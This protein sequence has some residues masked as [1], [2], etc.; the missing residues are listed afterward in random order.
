MPSRPMPGSRASSKCWKAGRK[1]TRKSQPK[2]H[3][4]EAAKAGAAAARGYSGKFV[5][6]EAAEERV[7]RDARFHAR[8]IHAG[9]LV[10]AG[11]K[12]EMPV[13]IA[14]DV[15]AFGVFE[16][17]RI[18]VRGADAE[19]HESPGREHHTADLG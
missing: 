2:R 19:R 7:E 12:C 13:R 4:D 1:K 8:E 15:E 17:L 16:S 14:R 10:D 18:A 11:R 3:R 5:I 6:R 9:A